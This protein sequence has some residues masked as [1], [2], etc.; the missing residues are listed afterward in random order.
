MFCDKTIYLFILSFWAIFIF[1]CRYRSQLL[2]YLFPL[3]LLFSELGVMMFVKLLFYAVAYSPSN[4]VCECVH[5]KLCIFE[6][7]SFHRAKAVILKDINDPLLLISFWFI[8]LPII[9]I[10]IFFQI[11]YITLKLLYSLWYFYFIC[12]DDSSVLS[13]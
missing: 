11:Y 10:S 2:A 3:F 5:I 4:I 9:V 1:Q 6:K 12:G 8:L 13:P 7:L